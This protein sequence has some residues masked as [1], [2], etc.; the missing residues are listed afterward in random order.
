MKTLAELAKERRAY[1]EQ[2][3]QHKASREEWLTHMR[4]HIG[5]AIGKVSTY[6]EAR[7]HGESP[8]TKI[9]YNEVAPDCIGYSLQLLNLLPELQDGRIRFDDTLHD[10]QKEYFF[11]RNFGHTEMIEVVEENLNTTL[12]K[13]TIVFRFFTINSEELGREDKGR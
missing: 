10:L 11:I 12:N 4:W 5:K 7:H 2:H 9:L 3:W 8:S 1:D 13:N 6:A